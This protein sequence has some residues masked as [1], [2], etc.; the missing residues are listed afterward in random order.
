MNRAGVCVC[1]K[2]QQRAHANRSRPPPGHNRKW[3]EAWR[4]VGGGGTKVGLPRAWLP[5]AAGALTAE[6]LPVRTP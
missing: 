3:A 4:S 5:A 1:V 2:T 6:G